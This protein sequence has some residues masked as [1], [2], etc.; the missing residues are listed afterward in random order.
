[1]QQKLDYIDALRGIAILLVVTIHVNQYG[2]PIESYTLN[3]FIAEGGKG[4]Q[5]FYVASAFTLFLSFQHK[6][7]KEKF[8]IRNFFLRRLF[9][10]APMYY[11]GIIYYLYQDGL[12][13]RYWLGDA[14]EITIANITANFLFLH[15]LNP[16]WITSIVH[17]GWSIAVE[18]MFY[19]VVPYLFMKIKNIN[20]AINLLLATLVLRTLL[21]LLFEKYQLISSHTLWHEYLYM[22]FP[23]QLPVFIV[24]ILLYFLVIKP[25]SLREIRGITVLAL[26]TFLFIHLCMSG[27]YLFPT[28][29]VFSISFLLFCVGLSKY[30][31]KLLVNPIII[32][33][34]KVSFSMYLVHFAVLYWLKEYNFVEFTQNSVLNYAIRFCVATSISVTVATFFYHAVELPFQ[35]L[36]KKIID[37]LEKT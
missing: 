12:G 14:T 1:M 32:H 35:Q 17:G 2:S 7:Q 27:L 9:R 18:M 29:V 25:D 22:Y 28:H 33:I 37:K 10:I 15:G 24:G 4:V 19:V 21:Q 23:N 13:A 31:S 5:L 26:A 8:P 20:T 11:L 30:Q 6:F 34:G 3:Q 16:Y 36:G